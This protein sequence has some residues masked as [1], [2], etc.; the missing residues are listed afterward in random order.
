[1]RDAEQTEASSSSHISYY[2]LSTPI[3]ES[4]G[5]EYTADVS[6]WQLTTAMPM[7]H[8]SNM[9]AKAGHVPL[10]PSCHYYAL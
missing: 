10:V 8:K 5:R 1:M 4:E 7:Q 2:V 3:S 9:K 6:R